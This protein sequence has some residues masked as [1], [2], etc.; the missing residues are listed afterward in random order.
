MMPRALIVDDNPENL[1]LLRVL[2]Q[3][4]GYTVEEA[5]NGLEALTKA[6]SRPP[7]LVISD[8]LMPVLDGYT[9]LRQWRADERLRGIP[10][11]VYTATYTEPRDERLALALGADAF[12]VKPA[13]PEPFMAII[14]DVLAKARGGELQSPSARPIEE[15][16]LLNEYNEVL[17]HKL[18][19]KVL[20]L[21]RSNRE[22]Q[23]QIAERKRA[24]GLIRLLDMAIQ[25]V[26]QGIVITDPK[27][28]HNPVIYANAG[29]E[30]ITG[31]KA[32]E[33]LGRS[34]RFLQGTETNCDAAGQL[35]KAVA[36]GSACEVEILNYRKDGTPFWNALSLNPVHDPTGALACFVGVQN[37]VTERKDLEDQLR[38]AQRM[39]AV[40]Q[41]AGGVAHD[42]NNLLTVIN[43]YAHLSMAGLRSED[44]LLANLEEIK[45]A[46]DRAAALTRQLL[47]FG[48]RQILQSR[49]LDL[50]AVVV[51]LSKMMGRLIGEHIQLKL[52]LAEGLGSVKADAGQIEQIILNLA[53]NAR[54]AMPDGGKL[55]IE[56]AKIDLDEEY[57]R[58][59]LDAS[60]GRQVMLAV[61]DTGSGMSE[62][63]RLRVFEPF[64]TTKEPGKGTGLGL[65]TVY[66]IVKQS[67]GS[68]EV[69]SE[70]GVGTTFKIYLPRVDEAA[71]ARPAERAAHK[72]E[73]TETVL[74]SEDDGMVRDLTR[75]ILETA[76]YRVLE[77]ANGGSALLICETYRGQIDLLLT[78]VV[79]PEMSGSALADRLATLRPDM[80]VLYMSGYTGSTIALEGRPDEGANFID[81][82]FAPNALLSKVREVLERERA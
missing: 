34:C 5:C 26:S 59:R 81:K 55:T 41:L 19:K 25:N 27:Q 58:R 40:G 18:E 80:K 69:F 21:E 20:E 49:L 78:D 9:L 10:F 2:L 77:A 39:E 23:Q 7:N 50:N 67:G 22:M 74:L 6:R 62:K 43:G 17:V 8:L 68:I 73:G 64:F 54:D 82:P 45:K 13:E 65:S 36:S 52:K 75:N 72:L 11:L 29:F 60:P 33:T 53:V 51:D 47:A 56:T 57:V 1:Y 66:G 24:E 3:G 79:M 70:L 46:G 61:S 48:R 63:V 35:S 44:P 16:V 30:R 42:F 32:D 12:I 31:Y 71:D 15:A 37:D 38:Q 14:N 4:H 28:S 76:G